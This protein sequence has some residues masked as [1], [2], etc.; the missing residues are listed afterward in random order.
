MTKKKVVIV[1]SEQLKVSLFSKE[2]ENIE[3]IN[4]NVAVIP[5]LKMMPNQSDIDL[6]LL[7]YENLS[8][9]YYQD[10]YLECLGFSLMIYP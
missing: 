1:G 8:D 9:C 4:V 5:E 7:D 6:M 3:D 2:L 10:V